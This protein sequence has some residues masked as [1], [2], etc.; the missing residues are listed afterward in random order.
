MTAEQLR[1]KCGRIVQRK[2]CLVIASTYRGELSE[3]SNVDFNM[4]C[5]VTYE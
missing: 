2:V 4:T 1:A 3:H 5:A